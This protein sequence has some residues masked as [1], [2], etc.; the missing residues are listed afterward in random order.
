MKIEGENYTY[1]IENL[2]DNVQW[3]SQVFMP[4]WNEEQKLSFSV[5][6]ISLYVSFM[7]YTVQLP[8]LT[9]TLTVLL[10]YQ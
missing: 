10:L 2:R 4:W 1:T 7:F 8:F 6:W 5:P 3:G 9:D